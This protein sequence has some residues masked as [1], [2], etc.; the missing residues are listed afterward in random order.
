MLVPI[1]FFFPILFVETFLL[2]FA[3]TLVSLGRPMDD[4]VDRGG[5]QPVIGAWV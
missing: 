2:Q 3:E 1:Y 4:V 5:A